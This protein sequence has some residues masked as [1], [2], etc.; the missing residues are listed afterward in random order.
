M[1]DTRNYY[2]HFDQRLE[3]KALKAGD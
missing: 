2:T 3:K 1:A